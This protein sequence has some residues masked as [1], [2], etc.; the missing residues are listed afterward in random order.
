[1]MQ[2]IHQRTDVWQ[3]DFFIIPISMASVGLILE[4]M[5]AWYF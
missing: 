5:R 3:E 2:L 4:K 1:M